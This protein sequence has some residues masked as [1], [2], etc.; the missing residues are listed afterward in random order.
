MSYLRFLVRGACFAG[1]F[2]LLVEALFLDALL[3]RRLAAALRFAKARRRF[4][5]G[6][7][8]RSSSRASC[9][10]FAF[11]KAALVALRLA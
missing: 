1:R 5:C 3:F 7:R 10:F 2:F 4:A 6:D 8:L 11:S 9:A